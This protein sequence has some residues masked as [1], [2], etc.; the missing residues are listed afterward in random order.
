[1]T[2]I[3]RSFNGENHC[4]ITFRV[5]GQ[6]FY[7]RNYKKYKIVR[8]SDESYNGLAKL[9]ALK[10]HPLHQNLKTT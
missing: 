7:G 8:H 9:T 5:Y 2:F 10:K 6:M 4:F 3:I 1:M